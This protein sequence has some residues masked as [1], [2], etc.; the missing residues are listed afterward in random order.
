VGEVCY[1]LNTR[2]TPAAEASFLR[3]LIEQY[4]DLPLGAADASVIAVA[5][6]F[7]VKT[8]LTLDQRH[9]RIVRPRHVG[10]FQLLP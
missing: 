9:F 4:A 5:E 1:F 6:R 3:S 2:A 10:S 8:V 7:G